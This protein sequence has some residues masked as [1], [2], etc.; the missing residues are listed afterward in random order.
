MFR[1]RFRMPRALRNTMAWAGL[2]LMIGSFVW[3]QWTSK[4]RIPTSARA[5]A[6]PEPF[7]VVVPDPGQGGRDWGA[8]VGNR[9]E[10]DP[11]LDL[12][13]RSD[14]LFQAQGLATVMTRVG[15]AYVP[16]P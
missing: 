11:P 3:L 13:H 15:D 1:S 8:R 14:G 12:A 7:A 2:L 16:L 5:P 10:K 9:L 4:S 6:P